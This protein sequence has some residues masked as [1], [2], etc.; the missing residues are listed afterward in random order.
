M[1]NA[2]F[3]VMS[4]DQL[5]MP[6]AGVDAVISRMDALLLGDPGRLRPARIAASSSSS[7][8]PVSTALTLP[9]VDSVARSA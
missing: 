8:V 3:E 2:T 5:D 1:T 9:A 6:T 4:V 7:A